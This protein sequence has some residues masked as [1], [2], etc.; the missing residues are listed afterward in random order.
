MTSVIWISNLTMFEICTDDMALERQNGGIGEDC[1]STEF[2][3]DL[4]KCYNCAK[5]MK[6]ETSFANYIQ[7]MIDECVLGEPITATQTF[8]STTQT[9]MT[10]TSATQTSTTQTTSSAQ[11]SEHKP[12]QGHSN[13]STIVPAVVV[14]VLVVGIAVALFLIFR[15]RRQ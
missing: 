6:N 9:S 13:I 12:S 5:G 2:L 7:E 10:H 3:P 4:R 1:S 15:R 14:P 8:A 11:S